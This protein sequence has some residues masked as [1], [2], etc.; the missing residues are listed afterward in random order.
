MIGMIARSNSKNAQG[1]CLPASAI[2]SVQSAPK[3]RLLFFLRDLRVVT[4]GLDK[5]CHA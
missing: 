5:S 2:V 1:K 3:N 4:A